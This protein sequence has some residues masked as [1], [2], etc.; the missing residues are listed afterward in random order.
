M[1]NRIN[2]KP[3]DILNRAW[4]K[5]LSLHDGTLTKNL[6]LPESNRMKKTFIEN[7]V[8]ESIKNAKGLTAELVKLYRPPKKCN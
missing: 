7:T 5:D 2:S 3:I 6:N 1:R 8:D 4:A